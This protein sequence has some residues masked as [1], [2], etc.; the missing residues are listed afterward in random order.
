MPKFDKRMLI[1]DEPSDRVDIGEA[2]QPLDQAAGCEGA[3]AKE[4]SGC[5]DEEAGVGLEGFALMEDAAKEEKPKSG[6]SV[7]LVFDLDFC[8]VII[9]FFFSQRKKSK[10]RS[11]SAT[12]NTR[13]NSGPENPPNNFSSI[14]F[15]KISR[16]VPL[17]RSTSSRCAG[18]CGAAGVACSARRRPTSK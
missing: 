1:E 5:S 8:D 3:T 11:T 7:L 2:G 15:E 13:A 14:G 18:I 12:L 6:I 10:H 17:P 4:D 16:K 9:S